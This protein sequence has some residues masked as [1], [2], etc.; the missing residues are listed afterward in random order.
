MMDDILGFPVGATAGGEFTAICKYDARAGR[1]FRIERV[2]TGNGWATEPIDITPIFRAVVDLD[3][4]QSGW[5]LFPP[6]G[7]PSLVLV[8]LAALEARTIEK[9]AQPSANHKQGVRFRIK[10]AKDCAGDGA[11]IRE[12]AGTSNAFLNGMQTL[13]RQFKA[14]RA[15]YP[16]QLP[17][18]SLASAMPVASGSG[19]R[20]STNYQ[21]TWRID[22]WAPRPADLKNEISQPAMAPVA[23]LPPPMTADDF[24]A[25]KIVPET[26]RHT[27]A[28]RTGGNTVPPP[29]LLHAVPQANV[30]QANAL[31]A[32]NLDDD[33]G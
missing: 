20:S 29:N 25:P 1:I 31:H 32:N 30:H 23:P 24:D 5:L 19:A 15:K 8:P 12:M 4:V 13:Y 10:L 3:N 17:V 26:I 28:P 7:A 14:E 27:T 18:I 21:P 9:P 2:N 33:F 22:G 16:G 6:G 11:Q